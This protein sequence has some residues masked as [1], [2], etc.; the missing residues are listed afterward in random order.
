MK[1]RNLVHLTL[2]LLA[3]ASLT[4]CGTTA[5]HTSYFS[6]YNS[7]TKD[8]NYYRVQVTAHTDDGKSAWQTGWY[9]R[10]ALDEIFT[11]ITTNSAPV[12]DQ[13]VDLYEKTFLDL[14]THYTSCLETNGIDEA[15]KSKQSMNEL[16]GAAGIYLSA[17]ATTKD[18]AENAGKRYVYSFTADPTLLER[19]IADALNSDE[20]S[21][22]LTSLITATSPIGRQSSQ[23]NQQLSLS[24]GESKNMAQRIQQAIDAT[25]QAISNFATLTAAQQAALIDKLTVLLAAAG[26]SSE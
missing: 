17:G 18:A 21:A 2:F 6:A 10:K 4:G 11:E 3:G 12:S 16:I 25:N 13:M 22:T 14:F 9:S 20:T 7:D 26:A 1:N 8:R 23:Q 5:T 24:Y 19:M 15:R